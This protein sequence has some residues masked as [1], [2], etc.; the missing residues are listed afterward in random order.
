MASR[1][2]ESEISGSL[3]SS[4]LT[5]RVRLMVAANGERGRPGALED[6]TSGL[7]LG[8]GISCAVAT[9]ATAVVS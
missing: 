4:D 9:M 3:N 5:V 8:S 7:V 1:N 6:E 2:S